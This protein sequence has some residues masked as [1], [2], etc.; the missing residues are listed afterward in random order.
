MVS[1]LRSIAS[2]LAFVPSAHSLAPSREALFVAGLQQQLQQQQQQ[3]NRPFWPLLDVEPTN[4]TH[5]SHEGAN[6]C[7]KGKLLPE[8]YLLGAKNAATTSFATDLM[9]L[10]VMATPKNNDKEWNF[11]KSNAQEVGQGFKSWWLWALPDCPFEETV[12]ADFSTTT[13]F[14]VPLPSDLTWSEEF[15]P[16]VKNTSNVSAWDAAHAIHDFHA[17]AGGR[18]PKL[19]VLLREPL[20]RMQ[21]EWYHTRGKFNCP[22]CMTN[23]TFAD[24][25]AFNAELLRMRP[26]QLTDWTWKGFYARHVESFLQYFD[27]AQFMFVPNKE[28]YQFDPEAF[29]SSLLS[30]L[31][32]HAAAWKVASHGNEHI[33]RPPLDSELPPDSPARKA[34]QEAMEPENRRLARTLARAQLQG[35]TLAGYTGMPGDELQVRAWLER[36]W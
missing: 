10:G 15:G 19:M 21:S 9:N 33:D 1:C 11:F 7:M 18:M 34:F 22:G 8:F 30:W 4:W 28:Y 14:A 26:P 3:Q 6:Y 25:L 24:A 32:L 36:G 23:D 17:Q 13:L 5:L 16:G 31:G 2:L 20:S 35:A 12:L 29:S 27:A